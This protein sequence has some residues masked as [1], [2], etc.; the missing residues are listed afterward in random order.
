[1]AVLLENNDLEG[2]SELPSLGDSIIIM[3]VVWGLILDDDVFKRR[4]FHFD[5]LLERQN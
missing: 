2:L 3:S 5:F 1:M 4:S